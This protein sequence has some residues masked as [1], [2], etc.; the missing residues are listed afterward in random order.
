V[1]HPG[2]PPAEP[3]IIWSDD[4][5]EH[6]DEGEQVNLITEPESCLLKQAIHGPQS[7]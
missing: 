6:A 1:K 5:E 3:P 2:E 7:D 4:D